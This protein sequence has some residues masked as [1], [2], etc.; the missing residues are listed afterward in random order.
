MGL[1]DV[2]L[3]PAASHA[4]DNLRVARRPVGGGRATAFAST[5]HIGIRTTCVEM[6]PEIVETA[7]LFIHLPISIPVTAAPP[8]SNIA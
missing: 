6:Y 7:G 5:Q 8:F 1:D 4:I 3:H 2:L